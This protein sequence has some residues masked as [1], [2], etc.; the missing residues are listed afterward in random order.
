VVYEFSGDPVVAGFADSLAGPHANMTG[1]TFMAPELTAKR[2]EILRELI[3]AL[4]PV[5]ILTYPEHPG[6][7]SC[8]LGLLRMLTQKEKERK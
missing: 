5:A 8:P 4:R 7:H 1:V 3:P 6:Q 2:L